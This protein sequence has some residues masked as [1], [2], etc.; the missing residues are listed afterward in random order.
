M[1]IDERENELFERER[2]PTGPPRRRWKTKRNQTW[3]IQTDTWPVTRYQRSRS[4][5]YLSVD[6]NSCRDFL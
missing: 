1:E 3:I 6:Y 2:E 4:D 5:Y